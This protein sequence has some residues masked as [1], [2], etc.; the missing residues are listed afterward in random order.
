MHAIVCKCMPA[1]CGQLRSIVI[2]HRTIMMADNNSRAELGLQAA[3]EATVYRPPSSPASAASSSS[4]VR[5][6][7]VGGTRRVWCASASAV[8]SRGPLQD[9]LQATNS[10][11]VV[12]GCSAAHGGG[13]QRAA[14][15]RP[16]PI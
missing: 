9:P 2:M 14:R 13:E 1:A 3:G 4:L 7:A 15:A 16:R 11:V 8:P 12:A 5:G 10:C 6:S